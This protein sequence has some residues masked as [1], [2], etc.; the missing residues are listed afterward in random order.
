MKF[1][2][3]LFPL[4]FILLFSCQPVAKTPAPPA[5]VRFRTTPPSKLYFNN[6]RSTAYT[7]T[8]DEVTQ[9][10]QYQLRKWPDT[11]TTPFLLPVIV[12]NWLH[13]Q[14]YLQLNWIPTNEQPTLPFRIRAFS[15]S[16]EQYFSIEDWTWKSQHDLGQQMYLALLKGQQLQLVKADSTQVLLFGD[17]ETKSLFR[18]TL[19]DYQNLTEK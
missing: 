14:A 13:D 5:D 11:G 8:S 7:M 2:S 9:A 3:L 15:H 10:H 17:D 18:T 12:D 19:Q 1:S 16:A 6:I 4:V